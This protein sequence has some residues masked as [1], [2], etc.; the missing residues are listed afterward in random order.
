MTFTFVMPDVAGMIS[1]GN[2]YN[3]ALVSA[4][5]DAGADIIVRALAD[6]EAAAARDEPGACWLVDSLHLDALP[7]LRRRGRATILLAHYLPSLVAAG[8]VP[9]PATLSTEE[10]AALAAADGAVVPSRFMADALAQLGLA[11]ERIVVVAPAIDVPATLRLEPDEDD[12][13]SIG[14]DERDVRSI[15]PDERAVRSIVPDKRDLLQ[16]IVVANVVPGKRVLPLAD[17][18]APELRAGLPLRLTIAGSLTMDRAYADACRARLAAEP[19]VAGAVTLAGP[20]AHDQLLARLAA[21]DVLL[22][23]S[24]MESFGL[25]LAE[26]RALGVPIV[27]HAGGNSAAHVEARAGGVLV[28]DDAALAAECA[29]LA[30][31][32]DERRRRRAAARAHRP[33][34]RRWSDAARELCAAHFRASE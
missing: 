32:R 14:P 18:L 28:H 13:R 27:A 12:V 24:R 26:A 6:A 30:R 17:A 34:P 21:S 22:S 9:A 20:V 33:P 29:R 23:P 5:R 31:D 1:G 3:A 8:A 19:R 10:R 25:A 15:G 4:L 11:R 16:A 2:V 7:R